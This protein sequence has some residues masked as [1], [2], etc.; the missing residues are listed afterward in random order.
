MTCS[1]ST[2]SHILDGGQLLLGPQIAAVGRDARLVTI[3]TGGNDV[4]YVGDLMAASGGMGWLGG[5]LHGEIKAAPDRPYAQVAEKIG[6]IIKQVKVKAPEARIIIVSYPTILPPQGNCA[7]TG[8]SDRQADISRMVASQ[9]ATVTRDAAAKAD[10][11]LVDMARLSAGHDVCSAYPWVNG[12][13]P[14]TGSAFHPNAAGT[15]AMAAQVTAAFRA[16]DV[17]A[18][19][20]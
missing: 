16:A 19:G 13:T 5:W 18:Q 2:A 1:G 4:G 12:A 6:P 14:K 8:I 9:L 3:T 11:L 7:A 17:G 15:E 20:S 10:A